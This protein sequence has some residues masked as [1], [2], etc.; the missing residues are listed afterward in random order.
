MRGKQVWSFKLIL[1]FS[2]YRILNNRKKRLNEGNKFELE[3]CDYGMQNCVKVLKSERAEE[4]HLVSNENYYVMNLD[5]GLK[6]EV[7]EKLRLNTFL[8]A[9]SGSQGVTITMSVPSFIRL[10]VR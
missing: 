1:N 7:Y 6:R 9:P 2:F 8:L 10:S 5:E 4:C 3:N